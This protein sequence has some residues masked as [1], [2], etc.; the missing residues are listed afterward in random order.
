[1]AMWCVAG[2]VAGGRRSVGAGSGRMGSGSVGSRREAKYMV[3]KRWRWRYEAGEEAHSSAV[4]QWRALL[5]ARRSEGV[6]ML[7]L[8]AV[9]KARVAAAKA[10]HGMAWRRA[11][12]GRVAQHGQHGGKGARYGL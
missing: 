11:A 5:L 12:A 9:A 7:A 1:M 8:A 6:V 4:W 2:A 10:K 3:K